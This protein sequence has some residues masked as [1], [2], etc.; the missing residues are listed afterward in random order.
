MRLN[1]PPESMFLFLYRTQQEQVKRSRQH[2]WEKFLAKV[3]LRLVPRRRPIW[4]TIAFWNNEKHCTPPLKK[5]N[6]EWKHSLNNVVQ[7]RASI[8]TALQCLFRILFDPAVFL[9]RW[10]SNTWLFSSREN[11]WLYLSKQGN[12]RKV[13]YHRMKTFQL[14]GWW[15]LIRQLDT[16]QVYGDRV[17]Y[18]TEG[19][20]LL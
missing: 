2:I 3:F 10:S 15:A 18:M 17:S 12:P 14:T 8:T 11:Y 19:W 13:R 6:A 7:H 20:P 1:T 4:K 9:K 16:M 5:S